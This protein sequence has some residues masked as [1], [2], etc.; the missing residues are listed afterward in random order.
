ME[1]A[2][3]EGFQEW[4]STIMYSRWF[5]AVIAF[6]G[7]FFAA[8]FVFGLVWLFRRNENIHKISESDLPADTSFDYS[9]SLAAVGKLNG[10]SPSVL[11][12]ACN[13]N[14][15]PV[16]IPVNMAIRLAAS[17]KCLLI[18]LDTK[19][20]ALA[21]VF[22]ITPEACTSASTPVIT[23]IKNLHIWPAHY[24]SRFRQMDLKS[25]LIAAKQKYDVILL[26]AP[27]LVT[28]P[29]RR[30][31]V[32]SA[33][34]AMVFVNDKKTAD[35]ILKLLKSGS[36]TILTTLGPNGQPLN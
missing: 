12:A 13:L 16:T 31:I 27:Y 34:S 26:N 20:D 30:R 21:H 19:R 10:K 4:V 28:H 25:V 18:D 2:F 24:F 8:M 3:T 29:D 23:P 14:D 32:K 33:E 7:L 9:P 17:C 6:M 5:Y 1:T 11:L 22:E 36:C 15:L 35:A